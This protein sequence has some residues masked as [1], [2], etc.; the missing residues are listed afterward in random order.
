MSSHG[1][2]FV[3]LGT[4]H[5]VSQI[6]SRVQMLLCARPVPREAV[7]FRQDRA[8]TE[9]RLDPRYWVGTV[10]SSDSK[11]AP[12][13]RRDG[14]GLTVLLSLPGARA[15]VTM[16]DRVVAALAAATPDDR[17]GAAVAGLL[18]KEHAAIHLA[19]A[20]EEWRLY[21]PWPERT[22]W[23]CSPERLPSIWDFSSTFAKNPYARLPAAAGDLV[24]ASTASRRALGE[25]DAR[26][27]EDGGPAVL[28]SLIGPP[29]VAGAPSVTPP[30]SATVVE[31]L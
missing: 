12:L 10:A 26:F 9:E 20:T 28:G 2:R 18:G 31:V 6:A 24:I 3:L 4:P 30:A 29:P 16:V 8:S 11:A 27:L 25:A 23:L 19:K 21:F 1:G 22:A 13:L 7:G 17:T 5:S 14:S 15:L